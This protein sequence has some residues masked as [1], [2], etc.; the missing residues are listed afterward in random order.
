MLNYLKY[1]FLP[2]FYLALSLQVVSNS[3]SETRFTERFAELS[4][5]Y[6]LYLLLFFFNS[7]LEA[8]FCRHSKR[9]C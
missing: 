8:A 4:Y 2:F 5:L 6:P 1:F 9:R 3:F 7:P